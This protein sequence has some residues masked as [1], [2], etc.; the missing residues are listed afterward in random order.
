MTLLCWG[1]RLLPRDNRTLTWCAWPA[2]IRCVVG[3]NLFQYY[4]SVTIR[5]M[6]TGSQNVWSQVGAEEMKVRK[7]E[8]INITESCHCRQWAQC[9]VE[10]DQCSPVAAWP[11]WPG[12]PAA[13]WIRISS[14]RHCHVCRSRGQGCLWCELSTLTSL[15]VLLYILSGWWRRT[16]GV[17]AG[18]SVVSGGDC[19]LWYRMWQSWSSRSLHQ[20]H[21]LLSVA[22]ENYSVKKEEEEITVLKH[23]SCD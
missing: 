15:S 22:W 9:G 16:S 6:K 2:L 23:F 10:G 17:W 11:V 1:S 21:Q 8:I 14:T 20:D 13:V 12:S 4:F 5:W 19:Q 7:L 18:R 3:E